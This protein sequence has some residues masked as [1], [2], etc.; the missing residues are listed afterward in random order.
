MAR[1]RIVPERSWMWI[2]ARSNLH[3]I[4]HRCDGLEGHVELTVTDDGVV[5]LTAPASGRVTFD[6]ARLSSGNVLETRELHRRIDVRRFPTIEGTLVDLQR[7]DGADRYL[8][9]GDLTFRGVTRRHRDE[10][11]IRVVD[12]ATLSLEGQSTFDIRDF[13]M[14]PP[15]LLFLKVEP[16]VDV[17]IG[18]VAV[19][20]D[21]AEGMPSA[22]QPREA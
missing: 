18:I 17:R 20:D 13:G 22:T 4:H 7:L 14:A 2:D 8:V 1:F 15:S 10:M 3:G 12:D 16:M 11:R 5:D 21:L 6:A 19:R 9:A